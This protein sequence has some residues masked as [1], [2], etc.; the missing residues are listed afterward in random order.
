MNN[1][2]GRGGSHWACARRRDP[3]PFSPSP[4][5]CSCCWCCLLQKVSGREKRIE[6]R[7][8]RM[9]CWE[10]GIEREK[11]E[12]WG[13]GRTNEHAERRKRRPP[14][15]TAMLSPKIR[16]TKRGERAESGV[17]FSL[18][19]LSNHTTAIYCM[20]ME[21]MGG[22]HRSFYY[23][24]VNDI[25]ISCFILIMLI[26]CLSVNCCFWCIEWWMSKWCRCV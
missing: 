15:M 12:G 9:V 26:R 13:A 25:I 1:V 8:E 14:A 6:D 10:R 17:F 7:Q 11:R 22:T 5:A 24:A 20:W 21:H 16:Q 19:L 2:E 3:S 4:L 23:D 18:P